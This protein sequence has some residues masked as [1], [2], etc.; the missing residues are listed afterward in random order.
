MH[1]DFLTGSLAQYFSRRF[2]VT[3]LLFLQGCSY[4]TQKNPGLGI[5]WLPE[6]IVPV[7]GRVTTLFGVGHDGIDIAAK[8]GTPVKAADDGVVKFSGYIRGYGKT[9][10]ISHKSNMI[11]LYA[12]LNTAHVKKQ[13]RISKGQIIGT[14]GSTG[15]S[16]GPHLHFETRINNRPYDPNQ[17]F[18]L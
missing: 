8:R 15:R 6:F 3:L 16:T 17:F 13:G 5:T 4:S 10:I 14:V 11:T 12:H 9:I 1:N 7:R 2:I 18:P